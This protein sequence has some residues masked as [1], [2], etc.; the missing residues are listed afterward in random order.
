M[1]LIAPVDNEQRESGVAEH[2][3]AGLEQLEL[4]ICAVCARKS[5]IFQSIVASHVEP[6]A[7]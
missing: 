1:R 5:H 2:G 4:L 6:V 7:C 3:G